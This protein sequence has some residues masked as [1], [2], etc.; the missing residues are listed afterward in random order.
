MLV[1]HAAYKALLF[2]SAGSVMHGTGGETDLRRMGGLWRPMPWTAAAAVTGAV[3]LA[4]VLGLAGYFAKD[5]ILAVANETGRTAAWALGTLGAVLSAL[6]I[7]RLVFLAF[8][9]SPRGEEADHAHES[10]WVMLGP[11]V[12][13]AAGA[14]GLGA[15]MVGGEAAAFPRYL[16][17]V[18]GAAPHGTEGLGTVALVALSQAAALGGL[19]VTWLLYASGRVDWVALR[20]R[21]ASLQRFLNRVVDARVVDGL[22]NGFGVL[23]QWLSRTGRRVQTGLVRS[24]ALGFLLGALA[25]LVY[26]GVRG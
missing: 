4:G 12:V 16:E 13:L 5:E 8:L 11:L 25:L 20:V 24:Y 26:A 22:V 7:G 3:S 15:L 18:L 6:Y 9:G 21:T 10:P 17:P 14:V 19:L 2:L 1:A 23:V